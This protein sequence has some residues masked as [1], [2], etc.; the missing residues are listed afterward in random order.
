VDL[1]VVIVAGDELDLLKESLPAAVRACEGIGHEI[2]VVDNAS[3]DGAGDWIASEFP[4]V[5][6]LAM[7]ERQGLSAARN[8][9]LEETTGDYVLFVDV[10]ANLHEDASGVLLEFMRSKDS[11]GIVGPKLLY[12]NGR[13]QESCRTFQTW[14]SFLRRG[15]GL[16]LPPRD[17]QLLK[18]AREGHEPMQV[19][20]V[21][22]ACQIVSRRA[23]DDVGPMD[24]R[25]RLY[26]G[27]VEWC[28]RMWA[29]GREVWYVPGAVCTHRYRRRSA[30]FPPR[31]ST[32][33]HLMEFLRFKKLQY[34]GHERQT[35]PH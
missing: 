29:A 12:P 27:D 20:W 26:Y 16:G 6:L 17:R 31:P 19:G 4:K 28:H 35:S 3:R 33:T 10:D 21:M 18:R 8:I 32:L 11:A 13:L 25:F 9:G 5:I 30:C 1:S 34:Q 15:L 23:I 24:E 2:L 22:G 14:G 7:R